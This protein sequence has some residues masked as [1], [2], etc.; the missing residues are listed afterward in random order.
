MS[1]LEQS[2][3]I[4]LDQKVIELMPAL[5]RGFA[6]K[7]IE[8]GKVSVNSQIITKPGQKLREFDEVV[9]DYDLSELDNIPTIEIPIIYEDDD[10]VVINKPVGLLTHSKGVF[11]PEATVATWLR[12][13]YSGEPS[14]R[15]GI[16][17]R[18]DRAKQ[19]VRGSRN[20]S[21][22]VTLK[23]PTPP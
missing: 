6:S 13:R 11:N 16:V 17:H 23:R 1:N 19:L 14:E 10:C 9:V 8:D 20:S 4:R 18:L 5:S 7:L 22:S 3:A 15:A 21:Q 2:K 12:S